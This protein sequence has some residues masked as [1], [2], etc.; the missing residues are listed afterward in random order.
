MGFAGKDKAS[1]RRGNQNWYL[2]RK[3]AVHVRLCKAF[4]AAIFSFLTRL[5]S[6]LAAMSSSRSDDVT[7][8]V[9]P[10]VF[11]ESF[12]LVWSIQ[13]IWSNM[14]WGSCKGVS[15]VSVW[16]FKGASW[17]FQGCFKKVLRL[18]I[19]NFMGVSRKVKGCFKEVSRVFQGRFKSVSRKFK[20]NFKGV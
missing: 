4:M 11:P 14:F 10:S 3:G 16:S 19:E 7:K 5:G 8:S 2:S 20:R 1:E 12:C 18:F 17:K 6:F 9:C 15:G 13:S